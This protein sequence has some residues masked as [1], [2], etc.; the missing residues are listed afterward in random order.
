LL[1]YDPRTLEE[2]TRISTLRVAAPTV[3]C[4]S[5]THV[6]WLSPR[7][8]VTPIGE[9]FWLAAGMWRKPSDPSI[10]GSMDIDAGPLLA[11]LEAHSRETET[12]LTV[13][14]LV[15]RAVAL[16]LREQPELTDAAGRIDADGRPPR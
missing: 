5:Q 11:F 15:A 13:T 7:R 9:H 14:H 4:E 8:F 10:H 16:A 3:V 2:V 1:F 6:A 12:K